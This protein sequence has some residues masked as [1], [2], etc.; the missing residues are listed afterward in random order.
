MTKMPNVG[1]NVL[2]IPVD[3]KL[4]VVPK[5]DMPTVGDTIIIFELPDGTLVTPGKSTANPGDGAIIL[6]QQFANNKG[7]NQ[8]AAVTGSS[9]DIYCPY[10]GDVSPRKGAFKLIKTI[11]IREGEPERRWLS[12]YSNMTLL[13]P[14]W[15]IYGNLSLKVDNEIIFEITGANGEKY[16][17]IDY[18][19]SINEEV[20][21]VVELNFSGDYCGMKGEET[22][23]GDL[24][25]C[26]ITI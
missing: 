13:N 5:G 21:S 12:Q 7:V 18:S 4:V 16:N 8:I 10:I 24:F 17:L 11:K 3:N 23:K 15:Q 2:V 25:A 9:G 19:F 22:G 20:G 26:L 14:N 1:D 6:P